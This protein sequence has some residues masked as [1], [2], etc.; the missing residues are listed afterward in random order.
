MVVNIAI[1]TTTVAVNMYI[2]DKSMSSK[3]DTLTAKIS[4]KSGDGDCHDSERCEYVYRPQI[5]Q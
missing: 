2:F 3:R 1:Y 5:G 4:E